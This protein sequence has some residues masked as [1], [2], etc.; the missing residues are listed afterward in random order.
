VHHVD[1]EAAAYLYTGSQMKLVF[2]TEAT[3]LVKLFQALD[4][5]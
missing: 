5:E 2:G 4:Q 1:E 3:H